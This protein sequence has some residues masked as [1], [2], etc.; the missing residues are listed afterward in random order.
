MALDEPCIRFRSACCCRPSPNATRQV[1]VGLHVQLLRAA[2]GEH[3]LE[4][5]VV[6]G[7]QGDCF[8]DVRVALEN[9]SWRYDGLRADGKLNLRFLSCMV[10]RWTIYRLH[11]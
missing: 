7:R 1:R 3:T 2:V 11:E 10:A 4:A 8:R 6:A 5:G 9:P